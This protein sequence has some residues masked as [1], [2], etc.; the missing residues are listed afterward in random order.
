[1]SSARSSGT[2]RSSS[3]IG[4]PGMRSTLTTLVS[5]TRAHSA[6]I[7]RSVASLAMTDTLPSWMVTCTSAA[8]GATANSDT[9]ALAVTIKPSFMVPTILQRP[10]LLA[11]VVDDLDEDVV[12]AVFRRITDE[13]LDLLQ[14]RHS[15]RHVLEP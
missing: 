15:P 11:E 8:A 13:S 9:T 12:Q 5:P 4:P 1:M 7:C 3:V 14:G 10:S 6:M 2:P